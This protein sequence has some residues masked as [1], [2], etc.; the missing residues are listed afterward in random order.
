MVRD[1]QSIDECECKDIFT[2]V[3]NLGKLA[4][5]IADVRLEVVILPHLDRK[6]VMIVLIGFSTG[7][8]L[9]E[10]CLNHFLNLQRE[11]G[12]RE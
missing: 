10:K 4:L 3:G 9:G 11:Y 5:E 12:G 2:T 1:L 6:E 8:V 7:G